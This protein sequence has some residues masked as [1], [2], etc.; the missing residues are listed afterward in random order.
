MNL[1]KGQWWDE[2]L[3]PQDGCVWPEGE[4]PDG[5]RNCWAKRMAKR[6]GKDPEAVVLHPERVAKKVSV[7]GKAKVF[8]IPINC[9]D[10][11][12]DGLPRRFVR[13]ILDSLTCKNME[14][15]D[16]G[17]DPHQFVFVTKRYEAAAYWAVAWREKSPRYWDDFCCGAFFLF[18]A[19]DQAS[20]DAACRAAAKLPDG[21]RWGLHLEPMMGPVQVETWMDRCMGCEPYENGAGELE[22]DCPGHEV[23]GASWIV[24]G[25]ENGPGARLLH[26]AWVRSIRD[27]CEAAGVPFFLKS[28]GQA[29]GDRHARTLD[30]RTHDAVPWEVNA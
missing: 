24:V 26:P 7:G 10:L 6:W 8:G 5:C 2:S 17:H 20:V 1:D 23:M 25:G 13:D 4:V 19:W 3:T 9:G 15:R 22:A 27:Q 29:Q 14:R 28:L 16:K 30:G 21:L 18:S 12:Q 11:F